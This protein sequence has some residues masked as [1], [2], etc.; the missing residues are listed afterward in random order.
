MVRQ[1]ITIFVLLLAWLVGLFA[2]W[3]GGYASEGDVGQGPVHGAILLSKDIVPY[4]DGA[5]GLRAELYYSL[6]ARLES[7]DIIHLHD[8]KGRE[9]ELSRW[10]V[11]RDIDVLFVFGTPALKM[12]QDLFDNIPVVFA[13]IL[14]YDFTASLPSNFGGVFLNAS[15]S[16]RIEVMKRLVNGRRFAVVSRRSA[17]LEKMLSGLGAQAEVVARW[18]GGANDLPS[19]LAS[20]RSE[21]VDGLLMVSDPVIFGSIPSID[22]TI[23]W[24]LRNRVAVMGLSRGYVKRGALCALEPDYYEM[25]RQVADLGLRMLFQPGRANRYEYPETLRLSINFTT[26]RRLGIVIPPDILNEAEAV[27]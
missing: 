3:N 11:T 15:L 7:L 25:G 27:Y 10:M 13:F 12:A 14:D 17:S 5:S 18:I 21:G 19:A 24:G 1:T 4:E 8:W 26:A 9:E 16:R 6:G 20:L 23:L 2:C 22:F